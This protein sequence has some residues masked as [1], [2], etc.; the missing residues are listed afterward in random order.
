MQKKNVNVDSTLWKSE[1]TKTVGNSVLLFVRK[2]VPLRVRV[3][4][5]VGRCNVAEIIGTLYQT[6]KHKIEEC[7]SV[8]QV[9]LPFVLY[10]L[11]MYAAF[12]AANNMC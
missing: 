6:K 8:A 1:R 11:H 12:I 4:I 10:F 2:R 5:Y 9:T 7:K 3:C